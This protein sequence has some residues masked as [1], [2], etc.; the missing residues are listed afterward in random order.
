MS[1]PRIDGTVQA[2]RLGDLA[3]QPAE[4]DVMLHDLAEEPVATLAVPLDQL[5]RYPVG[6]RVVLELR[7]AR[8]DEL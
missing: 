1:R 8:K 6:A 2:A 5:R 3:N 7:P 4:I